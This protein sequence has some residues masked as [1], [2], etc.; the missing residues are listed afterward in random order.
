[1]D[2]L[3][4]DYVQSQLSS[5]PF[6]SIEGVSNVRTLGNY[7]SRLYPG[8]RT[9]SHFM[10]RSGD[11]STI[12]LKGKDQLEALGI[13]KAFDLRSEIELEKFG[14]PIPDLHSVPILQVPVFKEEDYS[15]E[16]IARR[17]QLYA[18]G[19]VEAFMQLY[20]QILEHGVMAYGTLFR[21]IRD[22]P[23]EGFLFY[24]TA[25]KDRT[26]VF[27]ALVLK[28]AGVENEAI[29]KDYAL[30][31]IGREPQRALIMSRLAKEPVFIEN[32]AAALKMLESRAETMLAFLDLLNEKYG[33]IEG[34]LNTFLGFS[35]EDITKMRKNILAAEGT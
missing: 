7:P 10:Y 35:E 21:H 4:P 2:K 23:E 30:T 9:R 13:R 5:P 32:R 1:M 22:H 25:G 24:C 3:D 16:M 28:L 18:S 15:P 14:T 17:Y 34:Y 19:Q 31:R 8:Q 20:S 26:G 6:V 29:A 27:A 11:I 12:T 33:G